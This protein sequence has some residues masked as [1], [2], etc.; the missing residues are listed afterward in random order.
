MGFETPS[1]PA[2]AAGAQPDA[3]EPEDYEPGGARVGWQREAASRVERHF[4]DIQ[5]F[6]WRVLAQPVCGRKEVLEEDWRL[7]AAPPVS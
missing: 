1:W 7:R 5:V 3:R 4:R 6:M 2:V